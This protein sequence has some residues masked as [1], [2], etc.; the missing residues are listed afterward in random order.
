[1]RLS[2]DKT[3]GMQILTLSYYTSLETCSLLY[4]Q[5]ICVRNTSNSNNQ[6]STQKRKQTNFDVLRKC[7]VLLLQHNYENVSQKTLLL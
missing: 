6:Q 7:V 2:D 1:M 4:L 3:N 5:Y